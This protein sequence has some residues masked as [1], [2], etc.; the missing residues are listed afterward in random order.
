MYVNE[1]CSKNSS[2]SEK[3]INSFAKHINVKK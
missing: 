1:I 3:Y 2:N